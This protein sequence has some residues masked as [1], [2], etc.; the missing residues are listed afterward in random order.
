MSDMTVI[1][2]S[3]NRED[4]VFAANIINEMMKAKGDSEIVSV[5]HKPMDLGR[6]IVVPDGIGWSGYNSVRQLRMG[7]L[8]AKTRF[9][10]NFETDTIYPPDYFSFRPPNEGTLYMPQPTWLAFASRRTRKYYSLKRHGFEGS[11]VSHRET[12]LKIID[13][14]CD[15]MPEWFESDSAHDQFRY[16]LPQPLQHIKHKPYHWGKKS[17]RFPVTSPVLSFKTTENLH[18]R[19]M[20][21]KET[22]TAFLEPF[23]DINELLKR[24]YSEP[25]PA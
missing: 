22:N 5:T 13:E 23:G 2:Y 15:G 18:A 20:H 7:L 8:E 12:L 4:S 16:T 11:I 10:C 21:L 25:V 1:Y 6:N 17:Q 24:M 19:S 14:W 9:V 3:A